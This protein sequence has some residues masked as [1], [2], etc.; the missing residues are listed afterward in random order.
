MSIDYDSIRPLLN[1]PVLYMAVKLM[2]ANLHHLHPN[3]PLPE[4]DL[5]AIGAPNAHP[6]A[7]LAASNLFR[8]VRDFV[9]DSN[10]P[11]TQYG[12]WVAGTVVDA[13]GRLTIVWN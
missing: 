3:E 2:L 9:T 8:Q 1:E 6:A 7:Q 13:P 10:I 4:L 11:L 5:H 12:R